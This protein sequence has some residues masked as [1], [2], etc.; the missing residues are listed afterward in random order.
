MQTN[1]HPVPLSINCTFLNRRKKP[2]KDPDEEADP[3]PD[4][5]IAVAGGMRLFS[6]IEANQ[7]TLMETI[8]KVSATYTLLYL[9]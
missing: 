5:D 3:L 2:P 9:A 8:S 7:M 4:V 1:R 6:E